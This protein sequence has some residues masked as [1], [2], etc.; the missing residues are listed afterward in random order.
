MSPA[1]DRPVLNVPSPF[2]G[3]P[4]LTHITLVYLIIHFLPFTPLVPS[5]NKFLLLKSLLWAE[6]A[7]ILCRVHYGQVVAR[8]LA[9]LSQLVMQRWEGRFILLALTAQF[10]H[11]NLQP[12][13]GLPA[14]HL[15]NQFCH[16]GMGGGL[17]EIL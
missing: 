5:F 4:V 9:I 12:R 11:Q 17:G 10:E 1:Q 3:V 6:D 15:L 8:W 16:P 2:P 14:G 13:L 7:G